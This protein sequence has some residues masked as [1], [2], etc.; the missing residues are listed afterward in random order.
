LKNFGKKKLA[1]LLTAL[2]TFTNVYANKT[3]NFKSESYFNY[4]KAFKN[5]GEKIDKP[6]MISSLSGAAAAAVSYFLSDFLLTD[7]YEYYMSHVD[8]KGVLKND[9][10]G[11]EHKM[12]QFLSDFSEV[13]SEFQKISKLRMMRI[14]DIRDGRKDEAS[15]IFSNTLYSMG[16]DL[17]NIGPTGV[18]LP[19]KNGSLDRL[20]G[21]NK[22]DERWECVVNYDYKSSD[23]NLNIKSIEKARKKMIFDNRILVIQTFYSIVNRHNQYIRELSEQFPEYSLEQLTNKFSDDFLKKINRFL[24]NDQKIVFEKPVKKKLISSALALGAAFSATVKVHGLVSNLDNKIKGDKS[25]PK[26][27]KPND[28]TKIEPV[29]VK[30]PLKQ[31]KTAITGNELLLKDGLVGYAEVVSMIS[32]T[33]YKKIIDEVDVNFLNDFFGDYVRLAEYIVEYRIKL[34]EVNFTS[35]VPKEKERLIEETCGKL[36]DEARLCYGR[37]KALNFYKLFY[38]RVQDLKKFVDENLQEEKEKE[39]KDNE[40]EIVTEEIS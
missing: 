24:P 31:N 15:A 17:N 38:D 40:N 30:E 16:N 22:G 10:I 20:D 21:E 5:I 13:L 2:S 12:E 34:E 28:P 3:N 36:I 39:E 35:D 23:K 14:K 7:S 4:S 33:N 8:K 11:S 32:G 26:I 1:I 6:N 18:Y 9:V 29:V 19:M 25:K 27:E 37:D